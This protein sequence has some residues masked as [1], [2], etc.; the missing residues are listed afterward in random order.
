MQASYSGFANIAG[1]DSARGQKRNYGVGERKRS[2]YGRSEV[3]SNM[4]S[5]IGSKVLG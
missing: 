2:S 1:H 5:K 4:G 3:G